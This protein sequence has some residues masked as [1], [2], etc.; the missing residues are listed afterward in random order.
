MRVYQRNVYQRTVF[1]NS[2]AARILF[3]QPR[4][5][6]LRKQQFATAVDSVLASVMCDWIDIYTF[7]V[8]EIVLSST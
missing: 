1:Q 5:K 8:I 7:I 2:N 3:I 6:R 4:V